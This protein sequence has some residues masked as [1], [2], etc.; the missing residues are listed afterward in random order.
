MTMYLPNSDLRPTGFEPAEFIDVPPMALAP[1]VPV[2]NLG[3]ADAAPF[4]EYDTSDAAP[5][6][7]GSDG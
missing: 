1:S 2:T 5:R 7:Q 4:E 3:A 6:E